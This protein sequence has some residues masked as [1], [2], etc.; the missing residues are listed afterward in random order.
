MMKYLPP[1]HGE[2][3]ENNGTRKST[4]VHYCHRDESLRCWIQLHNSFQNLS[5]DTVEQ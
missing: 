4:A 5:D 1:V 2:K 3:N